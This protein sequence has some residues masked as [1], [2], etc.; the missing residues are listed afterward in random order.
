MITGLRL[1]EWCELHAVYPMLNPE[2]TIP[3]FLRTIAAQRI[4]NGISLTGQ[5]VILS[6]DPLNS[7][8][9]SDV[10][11]SVVEMNIDFGLHESCL[12]V[13]IAGIPH[14]SQS[15]STSLSLEFDFTH[16]HLNLF[17]FPFCQRHNA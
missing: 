9:Y 4:S 11:V 13:T 2:E 14:I 10:F 5:R 3:S 17:H 7:K 1:M 16:V 6:F 12:I 15:Y 8:E